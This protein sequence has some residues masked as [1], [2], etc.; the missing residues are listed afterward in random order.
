MKARLNE[1]SAIRSI[2]NLIQNQIACRACCLQ[3]KHG[4]ATFLPV[5]DDKEFF[6]AS[7][8]AV[9]PIGLS[10]FSFAIVSFEKDERLAPLSWAAF[11]V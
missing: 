4:G 3:N 8:P 6:A 7:L 11:S 10:D 1:N 9:N 2:S 5:V